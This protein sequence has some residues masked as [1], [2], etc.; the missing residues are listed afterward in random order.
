MMPTSLHRI[1]TVSLNINNFLSPGRSVMSTLLKR[2]ELLANVAIIIVAILLGGVL[3]KQLT[4]TRPDQPT[5]PA[6]ARRELKRGDKV[7]LP[8]D[9]AKNSHTLLLVLQKGCRFCTESAPFYQQLVKETSA[10]SDIKLVAVLPQPVDEGKQYLHDIGVDIADVR[11]SSP[12]Q[13]NV[14]GTPTLILV[15]NEGVASD[16]WAG[17][18]RADTESEVLSKL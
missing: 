18:L 4:S 7:T 9:W 11:Q 12:D 3:V 2:V 13:V 6:S 8:V 10:R 15:N 16:V 14:S 5:R 1:V 17:K